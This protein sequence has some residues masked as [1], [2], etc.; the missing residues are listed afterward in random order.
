[1]KFK[2]LF[3]LVVIFFLNQACSTFINYVDDKR[4]AIIDRGT[5][6]LSLI[7]S[8]NINGQL[9]SCNCGEHALGGIS[10][11]ANKFNV[12]KKNSDFQMYVDSG[13]AF[14]P[15]PILNYAF[16]KSAKYSAD[17][18]YETFQMLSL[19]FFLPGDNDFAEGVEF[20]KKINQKIPFLISNLIPNVFNNNRRWI[21]Q[22]YG[23]SKI[24]FLGVVDPSLMPNDYQSFF[25]KPIVAIDETIKEITEDGYDFKNPFHRLILLSHA[26]MDFDKTVPLMV[27][28]F[29][30][31]IG[32]HTQSHTSR[33]LIVG[34]T[35]IVQVLSK[36]QHLGEIKI[37]LNESKSQDSF[38]AHEIREE[39]S[40]EFLNY[41]FIEYE[42]KYKE[43]FNKIQS[44]EINGSVEKSSP[45]KELPYSEIVTCLECHKSQVE[46]W[47]R[48]VH[49]ATK[50]YCLDCH[51]IDSEHPFHIVKK[52]SE[53]EKMES[54][55]NRC[56]A[57]HD[58]KQSPL[59]YK[60]GKIDD[61]LFEIK[62]K[63]V[64]CPSN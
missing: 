1:M 11:V 60:N 20:L 33:P 5:K 4:F 43:I 6:V 57:C 24:Y 9:L 15:S 28:H 34:T 49:S 19:N 26:G 12:I 8:H 22:E 37:N 31:I 14:F 47:K 54:R 51:Q 55:K 44:E 36:D 16:Q 64:S 23:I 53:A 13:D 59:W 50:N 10:Q 21:K 7:F 17:S 35:R 25:T 62:R 27:P 58:F 2:R 61:K 40:L 38:I 46:F 30:W 39:H 52:V 32:A 42:Q 29:D 45:K 63:K 41:P 18:V 56:L 3:F 48:S